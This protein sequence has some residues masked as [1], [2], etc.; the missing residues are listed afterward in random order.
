MCYFSHHISQAT[1]RNCYL[2][3]NFK[4]F[5][6]P[7]LLSMLKKRD[8]GAV[9]PKPALA[10][11]ADGATAKWDLEYYK[12]TDPARF[13]DERWK[14]ELSDWQLRVFGLFAGRV[15]R[16]YGYPPA[17]DRSES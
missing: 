5:L 3:K 1:M 8:Q 15:N 14:Q 2:S 4:Y 16:R 9:L 13:R 11:R 7:L 12:R 6:T 10:P 17:V